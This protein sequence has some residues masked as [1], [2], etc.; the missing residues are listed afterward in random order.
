M[1]NDVIKL[2]IEYISAGAQHSPR[3]YLGIIMGEE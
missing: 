1:N 3:I 2:E